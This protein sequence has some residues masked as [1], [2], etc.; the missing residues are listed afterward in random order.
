MS[1]VNQNDDVTATNSENEPEVQKEEE[2]EKDDI[3]EKVP[4]LITEEGSEKTS[5]E[6]SKS[7][8]SSSKL[9]IVFQ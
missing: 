5:R 8:R 2:K 9:V 3:T 1:D 4:G 6:R 7:R